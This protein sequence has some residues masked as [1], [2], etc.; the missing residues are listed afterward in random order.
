MSEPPIKPNCEWP[1]RKKPVFGAHS[2]PPINR[3]QATIR[4]ILWLLPAGFVVLSAE[5]C[6]WSKYGGTLASS[7]G[8]VAWLIL[9]VSFAL[10]A[11]WFNAKLSTKARGE[12]DGV[13]Y[14][15]VMFF[16]LQLFLTP[17]LLGLVLFMACVIDPIKF[18]GL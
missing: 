4:V 7:W 11:G 3:A 18:G 6:N 5:G 15:T 14:R 1:G 12:A 17:V 2:K 13:A 10:G 8:F 16:F 9:N